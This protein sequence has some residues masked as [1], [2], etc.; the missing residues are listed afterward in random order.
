MLGGCG[1]YKQPPVS[2]P[3]PLT[4]PPR[5]EFGTSAQF[6]GHP[7]HHSLPQPWWG[8]G[9]GRE[10]R[11]IKKQKKAP[12][13]RK[14]HLKKKKKPP[15]LPSSGLPHAGAACLQSAPGPAPAPIL[16][17]GGGRSHAQ[18]EL[19]EP[20]GRLVSPSGVPVQVWGRPSS[21]PC[22]AGGGHKTPLGGVMGSHNPSK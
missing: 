18:P 5:W 15:P 19:A 21:P 1:E 8:G 6:L 22:W 2:L 17:K 11:G 4:V 16:K 12:E 3:P 20:S 10:R 9:G 7:Y 13:K 14:K